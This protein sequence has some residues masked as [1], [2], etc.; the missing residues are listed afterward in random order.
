MV[1]V[2][3]SQNVSADMGGGTNQ[4]K[5]TRIGEQTGWGGRDSPSPR[6]VCDVEFAPLE[7]QVQEGCRSG[8][9]KLMAD[10]VDANR[11]GWDAQ[12]FRMTA[13][14]GTVVVT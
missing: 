13:G 7:G 2:P 11:L 14:Y 8:Y 4:E 10:K 12:A 5:C 1:C 9:G 3:S 6:Q